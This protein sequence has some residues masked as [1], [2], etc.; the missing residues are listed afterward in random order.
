MLNT[1]DISSTFNVSITLYNE[2]KGVVIGKTIDMMDR[3][4]ANKVMHVETPLWCVAQ[5]TGAEYWIHTIVTVQ[6]NT[7]QIWY[8]EDEWIRIKFPDKSGITP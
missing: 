5:T 4:P 3:Q 6:D 1:E 7:G 8:E 2:Y